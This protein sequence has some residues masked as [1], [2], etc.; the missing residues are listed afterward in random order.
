MEID[1]QTIVIYILV[2]IFTAGIGGWIG[3]Y[4]GNKYQ[5]NKESHEKEIVRN[6]ALKALNVLKSYSNKSFREAEGEFNRAMSIAEKRAIIVALHKLGIPIGVPSNE[7]FNVREVHF[8]DSIIS[9]EEIND[10]A[11]QI[12]KGYCDNLFYIDTDTYFSSNFTLF[13]MRNAG[14][15]YVSDILAKSKV[16]PENKLLTEPVNLATVFTLGEFKAIQVL[17]DQVRDLAYF[18]QNGYPIKEKIET[19]VKEIDLG[20]W[21]SYLMWNYE[22]YQ[23]VKAQ[24]QMGQM[25]FNSNQLINPVNSYQGDKTD[26]PNGQ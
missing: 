20:L 19:L 10:I 13:A 9:E 8:V 15:R 4:F 12:S 26:Q 7:S 11:L 16:N 18:D 1:W 21:D 3:A 25:I 5:K 14:K 2:P 6:I 23:N 22:N 24:I 17:R